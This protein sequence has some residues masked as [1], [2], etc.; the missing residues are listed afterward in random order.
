[1]NE[2]RVC[3]GGGD[4]GLSLTTAG[5]IW[6][7]SLSS[8]LSVAQCDRNYI[9]RPDGS[10][11]LLTARD[12][13]HAHIHTHTYTHTHR[14]VM[15]NVTSSITWPLSVIKRTLAPKSTYTH[16]YTHTRT[17]VMS[18]VPASIPWPLCVC[19]RTLAPRSTYT[20]A[21]T[22]THT[23][24]HTDELCRTYQLLSRG[25]VVYSNGHL[26]TNLRI[27]THTRTHPDESCQTYQLLFRGHSAYSNGHLLPNLRTHTHTYTHTHRRVVSHVPASIPWPLCVFKRTLALKS[28][29]THTRTRT[30]PDASCRT[31]QLLFRGYSAYVN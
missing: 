17:R 10:S 5:N 16:T 22:H 24:T 2:S 3:T 26:L 15:S 20:H 12:R 18:H 21:H 31:Y 13:R 9:R 8:C 27:H 25:H 6:S 30:H 19:K 11:S 28:T 23:H 29:Y 14:R 1:M 4:H 7:Q